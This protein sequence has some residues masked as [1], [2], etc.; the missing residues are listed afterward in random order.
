ML[1]VN[2]TAFARAV[3]GTNDRRGLCFVP[4]RCAFDLRGEVL[5]PRLQQL[6][7]MIL[8]EPTCLIQFANIETK[9]GGQVYGKQPEFGLVLTGFHMNVGWFFTFVAK[10]EKAVSTNA[11][12]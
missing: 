11:Q 6:I 7:L 1:R 4:C 12:H 8:N 10:E 2:L 3:L 9:I 5:I